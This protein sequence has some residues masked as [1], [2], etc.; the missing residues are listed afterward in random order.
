MKTCQL[1][2]VTIFTLEYVNAE[3]AAAKEKNF[4]MQVQMRLL[5]G[6]FGRHA[7]IDTPFGQ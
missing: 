4:Q 1:E 6:E 3:D 2:S 5:H 7:C